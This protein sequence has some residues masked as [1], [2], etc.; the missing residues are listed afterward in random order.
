MAIRYR[1]SQG[2]RT[3]APAPD[4]VHHAHDPWTSQ[5]PPRWAPESPKRQRVTGDHH[6]PKQPPSGGVYTNPLCKRISK[7]LGVCT[8]VPPDNARGRENWFLC[9]PI[10]PNVS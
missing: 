10:T 7:P 9:G 8:Y 2:S 3:G 6:A 5:P 1:M 4:D